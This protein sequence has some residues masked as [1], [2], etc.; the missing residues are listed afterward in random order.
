MNPEILNLKAPIVF[1]P[2]RHH[3]PTASLLLEK[4]MREMK[5]AA[6]LIEGPSDFNDRI[7]QLFLEHT[8]PVAIYTYFRTEE[9][10]RSAFYPFC[11]YSPEW[12]A[13][14]LGKKLG[15]RVEFID[16]PWREMAA[17]TDA[18]HL[19]A[20]GELRDNDFIP[21]VCK[22]LGLESFDELWDELIESQAALD[23]AEYMKRCHSLC[24]Q[25]RHSQSHIARDDFVREKFM[26]ERI[27]QCKETF[28]RGRILVVT[29]GFHSHALFE[30]VFGIDSADNGDAKGEA[31]G[32]ADNTSVEGVFNGGEWGIALT[33]YS[34]QRLDAL[35]GYNAGMP[36]PGFYHQVY[37]DRQKGN[38]HETYRRL[39]FDAA[40]S[41]REKKQQ[42]SSA[43]LIAVET[44]ARALAQ[45]RGH[46]DVWRTDLID[47]IMS[48]LVK[49]EIVTGVQHPMLTAIYAALRGDKSGKL[50]KGTELPPLVHDVLNTLSCYDFV[51][52]TTWNKVREYELDL[53][54][55]TDLRTSQIFHRLAY[56]NI[57]GF[58]QAGF[59]DL[60]GDDTGQ[61]TEIWDIRWSLA[62]VH[63]TCIEAAMYGATLEEASTTRLLEKARELSVSSEAAATLL[64][65]ASFMGL[66]SSNDRLVELCAAAV[67]RDQDFKSVTTCAEKLLFL[68]KYDQTLKSKPTADLRQILFAAFD[69]A[70]WLLDTLGSAA[71]NEMNSVVGIGSL[72]DTCQQCA[73]DVELQRDYFLEVLGRVRFDGLQKP[74]IR[75]A[76]TGAL[77]SLNCVDADGI[78]HDVGLFRNPQHIGDFLTGLFHR[79]RQVLSLQPELM[80]SLDKILLSFSDEQFL[81]AVPSMRQAFAYFSPREKHHL[82]AAL[83]RGTSVP[84]GGGTGGPLAALAVPLDT[85]ERALSIEARAK[86]QR[87]RFGIRG[88][89]DER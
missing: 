85:A 59:S 87:R 2:V 89:G 27:R 69:R 66:T 40:T 71:G 29:G 75:G 3:S 61:V 52:D 20:D 41:L 14:Q 64:V 36:S 79:A 22:K 15:A 62:L 76:A 33:P 4:L 84:D 44:S 72:V 86:N 35:T 46:R 54:T 81:E 9:L 73:R 28:K 45:L 55:E 70:V 67:R 74:I 6:V 21:R 13:A 12:V 49:D 63:A 31:T 5:P 7:S 1:F 25:M 82:A 24:Y 56:L 42:I 23:I 30:Q 17:L 80:T 43:D 8:L 18:Q 34:Y 57:H 47:A 48:A 65:D 68:Y 39:I 16:M 26:A 51:V 53:T 83:L 88:G 50:A 60:T 11:D 32:D 37:Q 38:S 77:W 10:Q 58:A 78:E 19:Y